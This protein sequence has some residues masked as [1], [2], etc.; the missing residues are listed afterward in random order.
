M[1]W[2]QYMGFHSRNYEQ[3]DGETAV[4]NRVLPRKYVITSFENCCIARFEPTGSD[5]PFEESAFEPSRSFVGYS[6]VHVRKRTAR[7]RAARSIA[8]RSGVGHYTVGRLESVATEMIRLEAG[9][10]R[11]CSG[12]RSVRPPS[13]DPATGRRHRVGDCPLVSRRRLLLESPAVGRD[14]ERK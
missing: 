3:E 14:R 8:L 7:V 1:K 2:T 5:R 6:A 4:S 12:R 9:R 10:P 11:C 13:R